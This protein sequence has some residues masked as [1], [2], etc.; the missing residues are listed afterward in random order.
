MAVAAAWQWHFAPAFL[1][2]RAT[3]YQFT[4][5]L[6]FQHSTRR[7]ATASAG[8]LGTAPA[9]GKL[10]ITKRVLPRMPT[11]FSTRIVSNDKKEIRTKVR[12]DVDAK[13]VPYDAQVLEG[14]WDLH[15][16]LKMAALQWR[17]ATVEVSGEAVG[18]SYIWV[19]TYATM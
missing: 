14:P 10:Q 16:A 4:A 9:P 5:L 11:D 1:G 7:G 6:R 19:Q 2:A 15:S 13:G 12:I 3:S 8:P 17:F 18:F